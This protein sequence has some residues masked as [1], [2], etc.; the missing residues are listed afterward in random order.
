MKARHATVL[1]LVGWYLLSPAAPSGSSGYLSKLQDRV[2]GPASIPPMSEWRQLGAFD[3]AHKC[4]AAKIQ[5]EQTPNAN[6]TQ[7]VCV[8]SDDPR[9]KRN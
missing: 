1:A 7:S 2:F 5:V 3:T 6:I 8:A 9:L 4:E